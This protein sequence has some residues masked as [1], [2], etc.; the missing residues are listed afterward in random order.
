MQALLFDNDSRS[1][2]GPRRYKPLLSVCEN[3]KGVLD[4]DTVKGCTE[5]MRAYPNGGCYGECYAYKAASRYGIDF[6]TSVSRRIDNRNFT[7][8]LNAVKRHSAAWYRVGV[9]GDPCHDWENTLEVCALLK[10][11]GKTP[12]IIT[13]H[14]YQLSDDQ[15]ARFRVVNA[16]FNTS[17]SALDTD[18]EIDYRLSQIRRLNDGG[19]QSIC[20]VVTC[21]FGETV[22]AIERKQI[23]D[24]LMS[25]PQIVDTPLRFGKTN[26]LFLNG[27]IIGRALC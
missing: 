12:V 3:R 25:M 10:S 8:V 7:G 14:W 2:G 4:V 6:S 18:S 16:V 19:I 11:A 27:D 21:R 17:I 22:W 23:Q 26:N 1:Y 15:I 5:G 24:C 9:A 20:R 13:K